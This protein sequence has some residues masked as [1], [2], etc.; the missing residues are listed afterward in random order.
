M[1]PVNDL[2]RFLK[3]QEQTY[4]AALGEIRNG[5]KEGHWMWFIFPQISGLGFSDTS[6]F[7]AIQ[8][9]QEAAAYL[10]HEIL[11][12]RLVTISTELL[13]LPVHNPD[14][15]FGSVDSMKLRS[16]MT[17]FAQLEHSHPVFQQVLDKFFGGAMDETTIRLLHAGI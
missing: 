9:Q 15:I 14:A 10:N 13:K 17:L 7:Y 1:S 5:K 2:K 4:E 16:S 6:K 8:G 12:K 3:A 11:G